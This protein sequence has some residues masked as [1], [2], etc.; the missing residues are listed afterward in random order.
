MKFTS[1]Y[2]NYTLGH[3]Q[4]SNGIYETEKKEEIELLKKD[5]FVSEYVGTNEEIEKLKQE[6]ENAEKIAEEVKKNTDKAINRILELIQLDKAQQLELIVSLKGTD[7]G[8]GSA[9]DRIKKIIE[10]EKGL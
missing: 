1:I 5:S 7:D 2:K 6:K 9:V 4:F 8:R 10:L 3:I